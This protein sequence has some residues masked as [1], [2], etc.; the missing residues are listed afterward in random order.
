M[1]EV[2]LGPGHERDH[3]LVRF[4]CGLAEGEDAVV[5]QHHAGRVLPGLLRKLLGA[6]AREIEAGH[7]IGNHHDRIAVNLANAVRASGRIRDR[8]DRIGVGVVDVPVRQDRVQDGLDR[9]RGRIR[10]QHVRAQLVHHLRIGEGL[11]L[12]QL[13]QP[14]HPHRREPLLLDRLQVPAAALHIEDGLL[15]AKDVFLFDLN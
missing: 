6:Q 2:L 5:H 12:R 9:R 3:A 15:F 10:P 14:R 13:E 4:S 11:E 1:L 7:Y 8:D